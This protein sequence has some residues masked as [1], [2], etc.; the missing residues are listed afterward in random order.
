[1]AIPIM[2]AWRRAAAWCGTAARTTKAIARAWPGQFPVL[3]PI[4]GMD[5]LSQPRR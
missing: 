3:I 4:F 1:M 5:D 2:R